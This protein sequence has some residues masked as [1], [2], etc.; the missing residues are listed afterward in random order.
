M[1][2]RTAKSPNERS[3]R[4]QRASLRWATIYSR[5]LCMY[6]LQ[7][8]CGP[9]PH[10]LPASNF[11]P[12]SCAGIRLLLIR[13]GG[14]PRVNSALAFK[15]YTRKAISTSTSTSVKPPYRTGT[16]LESTRIHQV[17]T[18]I[19][20]REGTHADKSR[21]QSWIRQR[22]LSSLSRSPVFSAEPVCY[23]NEEVGE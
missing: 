21:S 11:R 19:Q 4:V 6:A 9:A 15:V 17:S 8:L 2:Q 20:K 16:I 7:I 23:K 1:S 18:A 3:T 13:Q 22:S 14:T 5:G 12:A 10:L